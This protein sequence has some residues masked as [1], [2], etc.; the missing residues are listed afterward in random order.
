VSALPPPA[1]AAL[2]GLLA[3]SIGR[4]FLGRP[5]RRTRRG[6]ARALLAGTAV[7]YLGG[8]ALVLVAGAALPGA[9]L[10]VAGIEASCLGAWLARA[11]GD[12]PDDRDGP[13]DGGDDTGDRGPW[14]WD[15]FDRARAGWSR[16][17]VRPH[18]R[19]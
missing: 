19:A 6:T 10:V 14:D 13:D 7:C 4:A 16:R 18:A 15:A 9:I 8:A 11:G 1:S 5:A 17:R 12:D 2:A 3:A